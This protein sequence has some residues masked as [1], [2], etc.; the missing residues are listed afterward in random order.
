MRELAQCGPL[1]LLELMS[2]RTDMVVSGGVDALNDIFMFMCFSKTQALS[3][4]GDARPFAKDADGTVIGEGVG[5]VV[6]KR[7]EDAER[8]GDRIYAVIR[9]IGTSSDGRSQS[10][11][12]PARPGRPRPSVTPTR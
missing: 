3:P 12:A 9:G 11:Y 1:A 8:D 10:I 2:G 6:L 7:L 5:M 4:T